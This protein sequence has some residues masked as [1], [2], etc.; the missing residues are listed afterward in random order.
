MKHDDAARFLQIDLI[1][2]IRAAHAPKELRQRYCVHGK[3]A[4]L[5]RKPAYSS[6]AAVIILGTPA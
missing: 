2:P 1:G 3:H 4:G 5:R 6:K